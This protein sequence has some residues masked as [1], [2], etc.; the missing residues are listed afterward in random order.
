MD[1]INKKYDKQHK[2]SSMNVS[3][4]ETIS[5]VNSFLRKLIVPHLRIYDLIAVK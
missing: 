3:T 4:V 2:T 5:T 1:N